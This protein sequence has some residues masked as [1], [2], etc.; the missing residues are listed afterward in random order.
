MPTSTD[1]DPDYDGREIGDTNPPDVSDGMAQPPTADDGDDI[2]NDGA[3]GYTNLPTL[4]PSPNQGMDSADFNALLNAGFDGVDTE[5][6]DGDVE[7]DG[8]NVEESEPTA[9]TAKTKQKRKKNSKTSTSTGS[10]KGRGETFTSNDTLLLARAY[11][12][13]STNVAKGY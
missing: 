11:M 6:E 9:G 3:A 4:L 13:V 12:D 8:T 1:D 10:S 2:F 7:G 5:D